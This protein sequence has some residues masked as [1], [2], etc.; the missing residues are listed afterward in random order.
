VRQYGRG[1]AHY[2]RGNDRRDD[3][4]LLHFAVSMN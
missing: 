2:C 4:E 3:H 1:K